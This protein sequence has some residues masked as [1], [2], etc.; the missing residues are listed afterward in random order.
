MNDFKINLSFKSDGT[1]TF[2]TG[3]WNKTDKSMTAFELFLK[4][5]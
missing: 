3:K 4:I 1:N 5:S 2:W